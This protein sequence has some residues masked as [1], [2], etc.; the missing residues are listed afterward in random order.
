MNS[1]GNDVL[2]NSQLLAGQSIHDITLDGNVRSTFVAN[3]NSTG[4]P[5]RIIAGELPDGTFVPGGTISNLTI[6][7]SLNDSVI[8]A[9]VQPNGGAGLLPPASAYGQVY[10]TPTNTP[11]DGGY[12]TYDAPGGTTY[13]TPSSGGTP[14]AVPNWTELSYDVNGK[15]INKPGG[16]GSYNSTLD[17]TIDD[18]IFYGGSIQNVTIGNVISTNKSDAADF[19]GIFAAQISG[20]TVDGVTTPSRREFRLVRSIPRRH[21]RTSFRDRRPPAPSCSG[22]LPS[23]TTG[24]DQ[25]PNSLPDRESAPGDCNVMATDPEFTQPQKPQ[26]PQKP[27][28]VPSTHPEVKGI[29]VFTYPKVIYIF[30][31][32]IV[33][34]LCGIGMMVIRDHMEDPVK[35]AKAAA[36]KQQAAADVGKTEPGPAVVIPEKHERF[37]TTQNVLGVLFLGVFALNLLTMALDFPRFTILGVALLIGFVTFFILWLGAAF[38]IRLILWVRHIMGGIYI[39]A[40]AEFYFLISAVIFLILAIV[41]ITRYLDYWQIMPNEI[42]HHHGPLSDLERFPTTNL[43]FDKEVP[44]V[45]EFI[46]L[47][48]GRLVLHITDERKAIVLDNVLFINS[49]ETALKNLMSRM[50]VRVTTD[51]EVTG[52]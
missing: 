28:S 19:A 47:G 1:D 46:F 24:Y 15:L 6:S 41:Y 14:V 39:V 10:P 4:Y 31:T 43:K 38:D 16:S 37:S 49:V 9:S 27:L 52:L 45:L 11:G 34:L 8:A 3:P 25:S 23:R 42:L 51:Q 29:R 22:T 2:Y 17:P 7:G 36:V 13:V 26:K 32:M 20:V 33:S 21:P 35:A 12:N 50:E 40:N 18:F 5:T 30:P 48:A 44:D